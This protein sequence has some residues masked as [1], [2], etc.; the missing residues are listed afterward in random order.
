MWRWADSV[1]LRIR[2]VLVTNQS[3]P[4]SRAHPHAGMLLRDDLAAL[5]FGLVV[6]LE[7]DFHPVT[8]GRY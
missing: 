7:A 3:L 1:S 5:P 4:V 6:A 8:R 2:C